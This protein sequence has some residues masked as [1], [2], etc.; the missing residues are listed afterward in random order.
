MIILHLEKTLPNNDFLLF[1]RSSSIKV[2][3]IIRCKS[4]S[5]VWCTVMGHQ[6]GSSVH[7]TQVQ[8]ILDKIKVCLVFGV[9]SWDV[10]Q[11][12]LY[13]ARKFKPS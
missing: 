10:R 5:G 12:V 7:G 13:M 11:A 1:D 3:R 6:A 8:T 4:M 2:D 9:Q